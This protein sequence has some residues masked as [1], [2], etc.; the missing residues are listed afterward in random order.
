[1]GRHKKIESPEKLWEYFKQYSE[2]TKNNPIYVQDFVGKDGLEVHRTKERPLTIEGFENWLFDKGIVSDLGHYFANTD[3]AYTDFLTIC[4]AIR[5]KVREDQIAGGM[6]GIYNPSITQR[7]NGLVEKSQSDDKKEVTIKV[8]YAT[9]S[10]SN[11]EP[12]P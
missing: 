9:D 8:K 5:R 7:L 6:A 10:G 1:M 2:D 3:N 4:R 11:T 12:T